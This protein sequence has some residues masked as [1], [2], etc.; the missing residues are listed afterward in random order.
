MSTVD[1]IV[2]KSR[3]RRV[4][5]GGAFNA[6]RFNASLEELVQEVQ[7]L[8]TF[9]NDKLVPFLS[10]LPL[11]SNDDEYPSIGDAIDPIQNG[12]SGDQLWTDDTADASSEDLFY[13]PT[14]S[15]KLTIKESLSALS[16]R[17]NDNFATLQ[18]LIND[19]DAGVD[20]YTRSYIGLKAFDDTQ[21]SS[22]SSMDGRIST[23]NL[24]L[25]QLTADTFGDG[26]ALGGDGSANLSYPIQ[27]IV[28]ALLDQH[29]G[30]AYKSG[31][32]Y[33][34]TI[35]L[36]GVTVTTGDLT[37]T[38]PIPATWIG[39][40]L[41]V[42]ASSPRPA[43]VFS[44]YD[45]IKRLRYEIAHIKSPIAGWNNDV[46]VAPS[47][48]PAVVSLGLHMSEVG[49]GTARPGNPHGT[50]IDD[51]DGWST[52]GP[53][54]T[55]FTGM[56][57]V[58]DSSPTY[59]AHGAG[60]LNIINN[61]DSLEEAIYDLDQAIGSVGIAGTN[62]F[63]FRPGGVTSGNIYGDW[64]SLVAAMGAFTGH[65]YILFDDSST[66][67]CVIPVGTYDMQDVVWL[68]R[69]D[70]GEP[71][72]SVTIA[73][74]VV[75]N[76]LRAI[77]DGLHINSVST[78]PVYTVNGDARLLLSGSSSI[79]CASAPFVTVAS[80]VDLTL[81][82]NNDFSIAR[83]GYEVIELGSYVGLVINAYDGA[84]VDNDTIRGVSTASVILNTYGAG[85]A[86]SDT[87]AN[88][89]GSFSEV[90]LADAQNIGYDNLSSGLASTDVQSAIDEVANEAGNTNRVVISSINM[91]DGG[92]TDYSGTLVGSASDKFIPTM[93]IF[94]CDSATALAGDVQVKVG[95]S[96][97]ATEILPATSLIALN[98][99]GESYVVQMA[100]HFGLIPDNSTIHVQ[101]SSPDSGTAGTM[102]CYVAGKT[103]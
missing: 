77:G 42:T 12:L 2:P 21:S 73:D 27:Q 41:P 93:L 15:R 72:A 61:G 63:I 14:D 85:S 71:F 52:I 65:R 80:G 7:E 17:I 1:S 86:V 92:V 103:F 96:L 50:D 34:T 16:A 55:G 6:A 5:K 88:L 74:G 78:S 87:H 64:P 100:G 13:S 68:G 29:G 8:Q 31:L 28:D 20:S 25:D 3:F 91:K 99:V 11:G 30:A 10:S 76:D 66:S 18:S 69:A 9:H 46:G 32:S 19:V 22:S 56:S 23:N 43:P 39:K 45:E 62:V 60:L 38:T 75:I 82:M 57:N 26:Y 95:L 94:I 54:I 51:L 79:S 37:L 97:G 49:L 89:S 81:E 4:S 24:D 44:M 35:T 84:G 36:S 83:T 47:Y 101:V 58:V 90:L 59:S 40:V 98:G 102:T 67:P 33:A 70:E 53:A 48:N